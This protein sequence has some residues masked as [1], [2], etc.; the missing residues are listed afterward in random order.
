MM[1][2]KMPL[3][4]LLYMMKR[5][6]WERAGAATERPERVAAI[7]AGAAPMPLGVRS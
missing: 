6:E 3:A 7:Q 4:R 2:A 1:A 5:V